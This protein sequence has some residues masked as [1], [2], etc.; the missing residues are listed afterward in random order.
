MEN[1]AFEKQLETSILKKNIR[2][3]RTVL[4]FNSK[5][6]SRFWESL[7][8]ET[9]EQKEEVEKLQEKFTENLRT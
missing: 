4:Q 8:T 3:K 7:E 5:K 1:I 2:V 9:K 6:G